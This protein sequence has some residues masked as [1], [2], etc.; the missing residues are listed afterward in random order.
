M[1]SVGATRAVWSRFRGRH[2]LTALALVVVLLGLGARPASAHTELESSSPATGTTVTELTVVDLRFSEAIELPLSHVWIRDPAG[3]IELGP[4]TAPGGPGSLSVPVPPLGDGDYEVTWHVVA[5]D[6]TPVQG[7]LTFTIAAPIVAA[8]V[9]TTPP[10]ADPAA[11]YPPDTSL[12]IAVPEGGLVRALPE[13]PDHGHGPNDTTRALAR[14]VLN[15]SLAT[16]VGGLAFVAA[17]WPQ[18]A[19]LVRTRQVLWGAALFA[20]FASFELAAFQHAEATGLSVS[21]ALSPGHQWEALQFRFGQVAAVRIVLLLLSALLTARLARGE[22]RAARSVVWCVTATA[23][24]L[25]LA[26]TLVLLG[27]ESAPGILQ[28]GARLLHVLGVSVW[29]GGLVMLVCVV[30]PRRRVDELVAVLPRFSALAASSVVVLTVGGLVLAVDLVGTTGALPS[31]GYGRM[32]LA[33]VAVVGVL[34]AAASVSRRQVQLTLTSPKRLATESVVRPLVLWVGTE[35]ALMG[36]VIGLTAFLVS[37][38]P[39]A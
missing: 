4:S 28:T 38:V 31:T 37:R 33:K 17:V 13:L 9:P 22:G 26:E 35:V 21:Q 32:L 2:V 19:R 23:I 18:G 27:H 39:P 5:S 6:G 12:A 25:G 7:S 29:I 16:L 1:S 30:F 15:A 3:Y 24:A 34:L 36:L 10:P 20:T 14:G 11:D 8:P